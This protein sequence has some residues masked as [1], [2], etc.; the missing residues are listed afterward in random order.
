MPAS[1]Q[2]EGPGAET[3]LSYKYQ[4]LRE[5]LR[6]AISSGE[7]A[8]RLPGERVLAKRY[9]ANAKTINKALCDLTL[10]GLLVRHVGRGT[11]V[12]G[13]EEVIEDTSIK[14]RTFGWVTVVGPSNQASGR[15]L[16]LQAA[17]ALQAQ[18]HR[19]Q[20]LDVQGDAADV[21]SDRV[22]TPGQLR[23]VSGLILF[24]ARPSEQFLANLNRRHVPAVIANNRHDTIRTPAVVADYVHGAFELTQHLIH[25]GHREVQLVIDAGLLPAACDAN[26]GHQAAM[27]RY[28]LTPREPIW[29]A[30]SV[31]GTDLLRGP[32]RPTALICVGIEV[33][34]Q[35][36]QE[37]A[38]AGLRVPD[39]LSVAA[40]P[41]P[42]APQAGEQ[43]LTAYEVPADRIVDWATK[44]LLSASPGQPPRMVVVPG[45]LQIRR[46][47]ARAATEPMAPVLPPGEAVV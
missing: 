29:A 3:S 28:G 10:E 14:P 6:Q 34:L 16:Y 15:A 36:I 39:D 44:L 37:V 35:A 23:E 17:A 38:Q 32:D 24:A 12:A 26:T 19:L 33:A 11:F 21:L 46:S 45:Q 25:L 42:G 18:G 1:M 9:Q 43:Q 40:I 5:R 31:D 20:K 47:T 4:R 7:L 8:G 30:G 2:P 41:E 22:L 27:Q 13:R